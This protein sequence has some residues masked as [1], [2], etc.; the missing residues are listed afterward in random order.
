MKSIPLIVLTAILGLGIAAGEP[1]SIQKDDLIE[2]YREFRAAAAEF[3]A[4]TAAMFE[5]ASFASKKS[6]KEMESD[7]KRNFRAALHHLDR[8]IALNPFYAPAH[9]MRGVILRETGENLPAAVVSF[10]K[11]VELD[12]EQESSI[13]VRGEL[14]LRLGKIE[15]AR[16]DLASLEKLNSRRATGLRTK[17]EQSV[18]GHLP[19]K[20]S[21]L[22]E[23]TTGSGEGSR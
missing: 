15:E 8:S 11:A 16:R 3:T 13:V 2:A 6:E 20:P 17:I 21:P 1:E 7:R 4:G 18:E 5:A 12:P 9:E 14:L 22:P 19:T 23:G 10:S